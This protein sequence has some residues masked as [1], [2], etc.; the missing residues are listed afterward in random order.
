[1]ALKVRPLTA[2]QF[3]SY[4]VDVAC[5]THGFAVFSCGLSTEFLSPIFQSGH[6]HD[7]FSHRPTWVNFK[8]YIYKCKIWTQER[9]RAAKWFTFFRSGT[10]M[11]ANLLNQTLRKAT[12]Q[13]YFSYFFFTVVPCIL[14][15]S[16]FFISPTNAQPI[17]F[18]ILKFILKYTINAPTCFGLT[19][20]SS[21]SLQSVLR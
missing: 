18:K 14:M 17:C 7:N 4:H 21:G 12:K 16:S 2:H 3:L 8:P 11:F 13:N 20:P 15:L 9:R 1:M 6:C 10:C 5:V 19:K